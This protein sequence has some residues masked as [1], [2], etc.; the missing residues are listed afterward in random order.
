MQVE[1]QVLPEGGGGEGGGVQ[2]AQ[3]E[4]HQREEQLPPGEGG[5]A[6]ELP[7]ETARQKGRT[8]KPAKTYI[9]NTI[10]L[11]DFYTG[12]NFFCQYFQ[13]NSL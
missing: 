11:I 4:H 6:P 3:E 2:G 12:F 7:G 1:G 8:D 10:T 13:K 9:F 5:D